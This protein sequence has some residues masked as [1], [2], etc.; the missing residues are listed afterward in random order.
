M[1]DSLVLLLRQDALLCLRVVGRECRD[2]LHTPY[3]KKPVLSWLANFPPATPVQV[4]LDLME[5]EVYVESSPELYP[6]E[7]DKFAQRQLRKRFPKTEYARAQF[8]QPASSPLKR[9]GGNLLLSGFN[10]DTLIVQVMAWLERAGL[11]AVSMVS[12][13]DLWVDVMAHL[14]FA[15][16]TQK[17]RWQ[18]GAHFMLVRQES[19]T[20]RQL[21]V[22]DGQLR[23]SR[24]IQLRDKTLTEQM[25]QMAQ[26][27]RL[28]DRYVHAQ[29]MLPYDVVPDLYFL[30]QDED[31]CEAAMAAFADT[32]YFKDGPSAFLVGP[33][34][35]PVSRAGQEMSGQLLALHALARPAR[36]RYESQ[37]TREATQVAQM[38]L[39]LWAV[40]VLVV[41]V[42]LALLVE[43]LTVSVSY[44]RMTEAMQQQR[45]GYQTMVNALYDRLQL[46][47]PPEQMKLSVDLAD[48]VL[49][50]S[51]RQAVLP[52]LL[53]LS[54][55]LDV[56]PA[57]VVDEVNWVSLPVAQPGGQG[58]VEVLDPAGFAVE[59]AGRIEVQPQTRLTS[60][61]AQMDAFVELLRAQSEIETVEVIQAPVDLDT[62]K[63]MLVETT[64]SAQPVYAFRLMIRYVSS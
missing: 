17:A 55:A 32:P 59:L 20:F 49:L 2:L 33:S 57:V 39:G 21:L 51:Q 23:T 48:Q 18:Q 5:E 47:V 7:R 6:W 38:R 40:M 37:Q 54:R 63:P 41:L 46:P 34:L 36:A 11:P 44:T 22:V 26:E 56:T 24:V 61:L 14:W 30:A 13:A 19:D 43:F 1:S 29:R 27:I 53:P 9:V 45:Q 10:D 42:S 16:R 60:L 62:A 4:I 31:E 52:Y 35:F 25:Q 15:S 64:P 12:A 3:D 28:L 58:F 50:Q 8:Q